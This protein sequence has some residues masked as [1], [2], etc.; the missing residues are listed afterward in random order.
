M[1]F[2]PTA[3][4]VQIAADFH[5]L[6]GS[7]SWL[8]HKDPD[9]LGAFELRVV[10]DIMRGRNLDN[11]NDSLPRMSAA[12]LG[13][14]RWS[15]ALETRYVCEQDRSAPFPTQELPTDDYLMMN[16]SLIW[17]P[18]R[19]SEDLSCSLKLNNV[20]NQEARNHTSFR[21]NSSPLAWHPGLK[22]T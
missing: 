19:D 12:R 15:A 21:K 20:L 1:S 7:A 18:L 16:A 10:G 17:L 14:E 5:G 22:T 9:G 4:Y 3:Q 6:E 13:H 8:L 2:V 11:G